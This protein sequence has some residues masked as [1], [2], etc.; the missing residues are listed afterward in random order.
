MSGVDLNSFLV[1]GTLC[2]LDG[3][4]CYQYQIC[5]AHFTRDIHIYF[6]KFIQLVE[7]MYSSFAY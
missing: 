6:D 1:A 7:S 4:Q 5:E 3:D 2:Q